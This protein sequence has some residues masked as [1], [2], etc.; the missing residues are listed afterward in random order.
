MYVATSVGIFMQYT[1][2]ITPNSSNKEIIICDGF[3]PKVDINAD[4]L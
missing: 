3:A 1:Q 4:N 2:Q